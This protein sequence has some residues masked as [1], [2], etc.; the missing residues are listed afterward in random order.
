MK[1][2]FCKQDSSSSKSVEHI[3]PESLG[4]KDHVLRPGIV[5]DS[6]NNYFA[7]KI[8]KPLLEQPYFKSL[9][10]RN[11]ILTKKGNPVPEKGIIAHPKGG[12]IDIYR[13]KDGLSLDINSPDIINLITTGKV[14]KMYV[15]FGES[16]PQRDN[17]IVS[18]FLAKMSVE[19]LIYWIKNEEEWIDEVMNK[20]ELD[21]IKNYARYGM[22]VKSWSY[23]Q[24]RL[25]EETDRF[26]N[27]KIQET[28]YEVLHEF[29]FFWTKEQEFYF[30]IAIMGV[31]YAINMGDP[32]VDTYI[33]WL[34][35][36]ENASILN[37]AD[38]RKIQ[39]S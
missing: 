14:N 32:S 24:R 3:I 31:E 29:K 23:H 5:C 16:E 18:R 34:K 2:L 7:T 25:Y 1:C 28:P 13:G 4:N 6:C 27:P 35:E 15:P 38:E 36:N 19:A 10:H 39:V 17:I 21:N 30:V 11:D 20:P 22:G 37:S 12:L 26:Y 8:E 9:R 33:N